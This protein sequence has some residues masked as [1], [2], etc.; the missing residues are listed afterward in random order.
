MIGKSQGE[1]EVSLSS[2][3]GG[4]GCQGI[5]GLSEEDLAPSCREEQVARHPF[6]ASPESG[7]H[8]V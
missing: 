8:D 2:R 6:A 5:A 1:T 4:V 7:A 3:L